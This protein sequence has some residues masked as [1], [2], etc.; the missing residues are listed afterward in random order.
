ICLDK[1]A[2]K[3]AEMLRQAA[4]PMREDMVAGLKQRAAA[5]RLATAHE[6]GVT[7]VLARQELGDQRALA[8]PPC[9]Q[10]KPGVTPF[11]LLFRL[12]AKRSCKSS[13][14]GG[15]SGAAQGWSPESKNTDR[16]GYI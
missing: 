5:R 7:A 2:I 14:V 15:H 16:A 10:H 11:H 1:L 9:R 6:A 12:P 4:A 3:G 8:M 13:S